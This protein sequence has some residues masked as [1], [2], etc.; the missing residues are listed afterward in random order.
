MRLIIDMDE[1]IVDFLNPLLAKHGQGLRIEDIKQWDLS[2]HKGGL[3]KVFYAKDFFINLKPLPNAVHVL[4]QLQK[5][6][7]IIIATNGMNSAD[8]VRQ[9]AEWVDRYIP[10]I[11]ERN[12]IITARKELLRGNILFDDCPE[13][14]E[15]F[16]SHGITVAMDRQYN[17]HVSTLFRVFENNWI[18]FK[19]IVDAIENDPSVKYRL[20]NMKNYNFRFNAN[21]QADLQ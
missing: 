21:W 20:E 7:D 3:D 5:E 6:H 2:V 8:I 10:F 11:P 9:K 4:E 15:K 16:M 17:Q 1:V 13:H 18:A 12:F 14:L 19:Q